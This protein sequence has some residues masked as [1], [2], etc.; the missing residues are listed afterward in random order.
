[1]SNI[2]WFVIFAGVLWVIVVSCACMMI[3]SETLKYVVLD[4]IPAIKGM[5]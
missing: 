3:I 2:N 5:I 4:V 1:M